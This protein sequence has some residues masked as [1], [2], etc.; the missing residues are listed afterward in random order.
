MNHF[1]FMISLPKAEEFEAFRPH[2]EEC[3]AQLRER[4]AVVR[5]DITP[6]TL[7][8][9]NQF[10][11]IVV[12]AH[13]EADTDRL[14]LAD[15]PMTMKQLAD[16]M[17]ADFA[18]VLDLSCCNS[19]TAFNLMKER[20][21]GS[22]VQV[23][24]DKT[25]LRVRLFLY[26]YL[27]ELLSD[28]PGLDYYTGYDMMLDMM[29]EAQKR[30]AE[31]AEDKEAG[32]AADIDL[33]QPESTIYTPKQVM[34]G[35]DFIVQVFIYYNEESGRSSIQTMIA[36][37]DA[38]EKTPGPLMPIDLQ[39]G[40]LVKI[41]IDFFEDNYFIHADE[42]EKKLLWQDRT[43]SKQFIVHVS[44]NFPR[45]R[46]LTRIKISHD[47]QQLKVYSFATKVSGVEDCAPTAQPINLR[48]KSLRQKIK[49]DALTYYS[50]VNK[51]DGIRLYADDKGQQVTTIRATL[52]KED[53]YQSVI[54]K[55]I[56]K[57]I[58]EC[59]RVLLL[60]GD[61]K[62]PAL[63]EA[64][65]VI[66]DRLQSSYRQMEDQY[67]LIYGSFKKTPWLQLESKE[68]EDVMSK[69]FPDIETE[70]LHMMYDLHNNDEHLKMIEALAGLS[71]LLRERTFNDAIR[72]EIRAKVEA[73][74]KPFTVSGIDSPLFDVF[75]NIHKETKTPPAKSF[76]S[77]HYIG[78]AC[79][80]ALGE[81][82]Q[83]L[84]PIPSD[85]GNSTAGSMKTTLHRVNMIFNAT[86]AK[87]NV[88]A[89]EIKKYYETDEGRTS[90]IAYRLLHA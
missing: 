79:C 6:E 57:Q 42:G 25:S 10:D 13:H 36:D 48:A 65:N 49:D 62:E 20:C 64:L 15:G 16:A 60:A 51:M 66:C 1:L 31:T 3:I 8:D 28:N 39:K 75:M 90:I 11:A 70:F 18:G 74:Y 53:L 61:V 59:D 2:V 35:S 27:I 38:E 55:H 44:S 80:L 50:I 12:V 46:F 14:I 17:P 89:N 4:G 23:A 85:R 9:A 63:K 7:A 33:G 26:P 58:G 56:E 81:P 67:R 78:L 29:V 52:C 41:A 84:S 86:T 83:T 21:P 72:S 40:D 30:Q 68:R 69:K 34:R 45:E 54:T 77:R 22:R 19:I 88:F 37:P 87:G 43:D 5:T 24:G 71:Q 47:E 82:L 32:D 73:F 76:I